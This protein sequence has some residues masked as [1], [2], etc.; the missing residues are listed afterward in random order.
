MSLMLAFTLGSSGSN[1]LPFL[2][3]LKNAP[4]LNIGSHSGKF[5]LPC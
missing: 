3:D 2:A 4:W 1:G 5:L